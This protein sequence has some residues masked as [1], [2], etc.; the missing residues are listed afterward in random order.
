MTY[1]ISE[2]LEQASKING[3]Q[4]RIDFLR[5]HRNAAA[6]KGIF[7]L[8]YSPTVQW[9]LPEGAPPYKPSEFLDIEGMLLKELRRMYLFVNT[10]GIPE[11]PAHKREQLFIGLLES[12]SPNDA[13][14]L[15]SLKERN[16][17]YKGLS[18]KFAEEAYPEL[19]LEPAKEES[20]G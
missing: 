7:S 13:K 1:S 10:P 11:I 9:L 6:L 8:A 14:L 4:D 17:P 3:K 12:I 15:I 18:K 16:I 2:I 5:N 19:F 20:N